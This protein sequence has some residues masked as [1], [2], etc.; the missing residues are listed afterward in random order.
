L[1]QASPAT[2][3]GPRCVVKP[4]KS[5]KRKPIQSGDESQT[6]IRSTRPAIPRPMARVPQGKRRYVVVEH[7]EDL[8]DV[9]RIIGEFSTLELAQA[10][11]RSEVEWGN[12]SVVILDQRAGEA[13]LDSTACPVRVSL[14]AP[15]RRRARSS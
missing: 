9:V 15:K 13:I 5:A 14:P 6:A 4:I 12:A 3:S 2:K 10:L 7:R 11:L 1:G 8:A